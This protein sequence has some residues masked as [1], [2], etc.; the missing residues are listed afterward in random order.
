EAARAR[1]LPD[2]PTVRSLQAEYDTVQAALQRTATEARDSVRADYRSA[3]ASEQRLR[4][5]VNSLQGATLAEQDRSVRYNTL[6]R[7]AD[8]NRQ[9]YDGLLQRYRELNA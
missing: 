6:A 4:A 5:R 2:H 1:Y 8:T 3:A 9:I 7:E